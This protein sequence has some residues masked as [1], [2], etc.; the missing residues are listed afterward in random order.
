MIDDG[1]STQDRRWLGPSADLA[2][3]S[4][5]PTIWRGSGAARPPVG[6]RTPGDQRAAIEA[7]YR[8]ERRPY[9][10]SPRPTKQL[11]I[12]SLKSLMRKELIS[13][14]RS[15][16]PGEDAYRFATPADPR[17]RIRPGTR[18]ARAPSA[19]NLRGWLSRSPAIGSPNRRRSSEYHLERPTRCASNSASTMTH[20]STRPRQLRSISMPPPGAPCG[21]RRLARSAQ[22][23]RTGT[24][25]ALVDD[26][27]DP[28]DPHARAGPRGGGVAFERSAQ[29]YEEGALP[30]VRHRRSRRSTGSSEAIRD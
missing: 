23:C 16:L 30:R 8:P 14:E 3:V 27:E 6:T 24:R 9:S 7:G 29:V 15:S 12:S 18:S 19:R 2:G 26:P 17:R 1:L 22:S 28:G 13:P 5:P 10:S 20:P 11:S 21:S 25:S 4:I